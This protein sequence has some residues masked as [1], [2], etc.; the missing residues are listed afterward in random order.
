V[1]GQHP[2]SDI[3]VVN[4]GTHAAH[5]PR[6]IYERLAAD[7]GE[8]RMALKLRQRTSRRGG[9]AEGGGE[10]ESGEHLS[11]VGAFLSVAKSVFVGCQIGAL[12]GRAIRYH[13]PIVSMSIEAHPAGAMRGGSFYICEVW[14]SRDGREAPAMWRLTPTKRDLA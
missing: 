4:C 10:G 12:P 3:A 2:V 5:D 9:G 1:S 7:L 14:S 8:W 6:V 11:S 13:L